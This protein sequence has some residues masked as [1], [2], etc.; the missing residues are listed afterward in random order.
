MKKVAMRF[1]WAGALVA[2]LALGGVLVGCDSSS[3]TQ[4]AGGAQQSASADRADANI[5]WQYMTA[6]DLAKK[7]DA[8]DPVIVLDSRPDDMYNAGHIKG[9]YH[10]AVFPVDTAEAEKELTDAAKNLG[11]EDLVVIVCKTGNKGAKRA[12]SVL[13]DAGIAH[14]RLFILEGGGDGWNIEEWT[15][16]ENDSVVP[17]SNA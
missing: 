2:T 13:E 8:G 6:D 5:D 3:T 17:G 10:L 7:L 16:T 12:I 1:A 14:D 15:T 4:G 11:D 9:A